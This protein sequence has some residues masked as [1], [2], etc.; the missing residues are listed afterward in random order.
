MYLP[1]PFPFGMTRNAAPM[2][3]GEDCAAN[4]D[5]ANS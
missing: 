3:V 5:D 4:E 2:Q 1:Q